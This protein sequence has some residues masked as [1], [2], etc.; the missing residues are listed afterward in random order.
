MSKLRV[1]S[2]PPATKASQQK[3]AAIPRDLAAERSA[4]MRSVRPPGIGHERL[5]W[6]G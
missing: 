1:A 6:R 2:K 3:P 5:G 4:L